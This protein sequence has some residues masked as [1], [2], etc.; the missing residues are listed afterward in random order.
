MRSP[1]SIDIIICRLTYATRRYSSNDNCSRDSLKSRHVTRRI[2]LALHRRSGVMVSGRLSPLVSYGKS[3]D[4]I[5]RRIYH[6]SSVGPALAAV[7]PLLGVW[8]RPSLFGGV[9]TCADAGVCR[10]NAHEQIENQIASHISP[11]TRPVPDTRVAQ[12]AS[13]SVYIN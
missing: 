6:A 11:H 8:V 3:M 7:A 2:Y 4:I 13:P 10:R 9:G 5:H 1:E 12:R